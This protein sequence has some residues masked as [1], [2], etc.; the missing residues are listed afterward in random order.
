MQDN[1]LITCG[2]SSTDSPMWFCSQ[3]LYQHAAIQHSYTNITPSRPLLC[4]VSAQN[5]TLLNSLC[6]SEFHHNLLNQTL[7]G[8]KLFLF[9]K[10]RDG[11][12]MTEAVKIYCP[13][14]ISLPKLSEKY[15]WLKVGEINIYVSWKRL[16]F[17]LL[18]KLLRTFI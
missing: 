16:H 5:N 2:S 1:N 14:I 6:V 10:Q 12:D 13:A 17:F 3:N 11:D 7:S 18:Y 9:L 15:I 8:L 4:G